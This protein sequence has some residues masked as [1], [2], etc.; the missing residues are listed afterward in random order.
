MTKRYYPL[1]RKLDLRG[2]WHKIE[3]H[4]RWSRSSDGFFKVWVNGG[5]KVNIQGRTLNDKGTYFKYGIYRSFLSRS[6]RHPTQTV[7]YANVRK[8]RSRENLLPT[9]GTGGLSPVFL[10]PLRKH[11]KE[12]K[13]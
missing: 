4:A 3:V 9:D 11:V 12:K 5:Q 6:A 2:R 13:G 7:Y 10:D 8:A 1:I